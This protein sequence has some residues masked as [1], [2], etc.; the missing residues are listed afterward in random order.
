MKF[1]KVVQALTLVEVVI[2]CTVTVPIFSEIC[3]YLTDMEQKTRWQ[4]RYR[5]DTV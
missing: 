2:L 3:S 1:P 5:G 4:F